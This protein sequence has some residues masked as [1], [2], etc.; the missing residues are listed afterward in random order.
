MKF[1]FAI[2]AFSTLTSCATLKW[3]RKYVT[4]RMA[5]LFREYSKN[6]EFNISLY[7]T[8]TI[9]GKSFK[10]LTRKELKSNLRILEKGLAMPPDSVATA[11]GIVDSFYTNPD[12]IKFIVKKKLMSP[13]IHF[14][15]N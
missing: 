10:K 9:N 7:P 2:I 8:D 5:I 15:V 12:K 3:K 6:G 14:V 4:K 1:L 11:D 13:N